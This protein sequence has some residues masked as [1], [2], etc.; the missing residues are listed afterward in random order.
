MTNFTAN[1]FIASMF[2]FS[3]GAAT[4]QVPDELVDPSSNPTLRHGVHSCPPN[5]YLTGVH[6][7]DVLVATLLC[8][9][10]PPGYDPDNQ[11]FIDEPTNQLPQGNQDHGMHACPRGAV[12][13]GLTPSENI[14]HCVPSPLDPNGNDPNVVRFKDEAVGT[15]RSG[16]HAC[17]PGLPM[18]G[19][20]L[21]TNTV[22]CEVKVPVVLTTRRPG[23]INS[24][25]KQ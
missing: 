6:G 12:M 10:L 18:A 13:S 15:Q 25:A 14:F 17:P 11:E 22:L 7:Q 5:L 9:R 20:H 21:S 8:A 16:M 3:A 2:V 19:I 24:P 4:A 1:I 23:G